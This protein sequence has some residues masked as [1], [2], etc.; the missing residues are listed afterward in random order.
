MSTRRIPAIDLAKASIVDKALEQ[1]S[2]PPRPIVVS[3]ASLDNILNRQLLALE[4]VT[5]QLLTS[6]NSGKMTGAEIQSLATCIK[7]TLE[8]KSNEKELLAD[9]SD[10]QLEAA[11]K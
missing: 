7:I 3:D 2:L 5:L 10:E 6:A 4:R 8:L 11:A 9:L 1:P